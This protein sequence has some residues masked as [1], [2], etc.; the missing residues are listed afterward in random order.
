MKIEDLK[1]GIELAHRH[2]GGPY[3][4][5]AIFDNIVALSDSNGEVVW[6]T[7]ES[8]NEWHKLKPKRPDFPVDT[9]VLVRDSKNGP[10]ER[11]HFAMWDEEGEIVCWDSG[12]TSFST[13]RT[14]AWRKWKLPEDDCDENYKMAL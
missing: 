1:V 11:R 13:S 2:F 4:I 7:E 3:K 14:F 12:Y 5:E 10:W 9:K 8:L 6:R